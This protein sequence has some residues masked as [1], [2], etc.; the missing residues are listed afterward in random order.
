[1][2]TAGNA[3]SALSSLVF[4]YLV[5]YSGNYNTPFILETAVVSQSLG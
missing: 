5:G 3:A 1:M 2:N 4:G